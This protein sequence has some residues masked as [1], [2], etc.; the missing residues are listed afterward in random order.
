[1]KSKPCSVQ[2]LG[3]FHIERAGELGEVLKTDV[4][5]AALDVPHV[6]AVHVAAFG[7]IL[8]RKPHRFA[9]LSDRFA[10]TLELKAKPGRWHVCAPSLAGC[11]LYLYIL[12]LACVSV[13]FAGGC[14]RIF[15]MMKTA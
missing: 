2:Q 10:E 13:F 4:R 1:M 14:G 7:E 3:E 5:F 9:P 6:C 15:A 12:N 8:L 11:I